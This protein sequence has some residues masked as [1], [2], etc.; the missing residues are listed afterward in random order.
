VQVLKR[1]EIWRSL[2]TDSATIAFRRAPQVA[3]RLEALFE[4]AR[5]GEGATVDET[6]LQPLVDGPPLTSSSA[7]EVAATAE[8]TKPCV[9]FAEVYDAYMADPS[10]EW[11]DRTR[12][13]Y[14]TTRRLALACFGGEAPMSEVNRAT[15]R[16]FLDMLKSLPRNAKQRY[17][18]LSP[19]EAAHHAHA[20]GDPDI[21]SPANANTY[22]NKLCGV[23][24]W[25][26]KEEFIGRNPAKG[27]R[28]ADRTSKREKRRPFSAVQ[29]K[30]IFDAPIYTGCRDDRNGYA[31]PGDQRPRGTRF[32]V[33]LLGLFTGLRLN[34]ICQLEPADVRE[35]ESILCILVT[36]V[37]SAGAEKR[38]KTVSSERLMP[39][40]PTLLDLGFAEFA[41]RKRRQDVSHLFGDIPLD[42]HGF[43]SVAFS[44]WFTRF[45]RSA[46]ACEERTCYHSFRHCF[47][48]AMRDAH[49][50]RDIAHAL[51]G[52]SSGVSG[53][54]AVADNYGR[55]YRA[56]ALSEAVEKVSYPSLDLSHLL[57][58]R[59]A[60]TDLRPNQ[61]DAPAV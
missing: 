29:L 31:A 40:H 25:A 9:T 3:A 41:L 53:S 44:K 19:R 52:W 30:L 1:V 56:K 61:A 35:V 27:L 10:H 37:S 49:V 2:H 14:E 42:P 13:A 18:R 23:L 17:P 58:L 16:D 7:I 43:R 12:L 5:V 36:T 55:G 15:C 38:L 24:N 11:S 8:S 21:I 51:G 20:V 57:D 47:R 4:S 45:L 60:P 39:I 34:E 50:D 28:L 48:D 59:S 46:G 54:G 26:V 6:L 22:L 33:P 32:W